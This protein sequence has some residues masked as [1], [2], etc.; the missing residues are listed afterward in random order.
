MIVGVCGGFVEYF[1]IEV[2]I[3]CLFWVGVV[4]FFGIGI[5]LY[6]LVVII[7]L[8]VIFELEW[9]WIKICVGL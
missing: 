4:L 5:L 7:M 2:I 9:E 6:I 3:I 1:G 8:I